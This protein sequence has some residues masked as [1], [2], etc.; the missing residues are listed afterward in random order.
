MTLEAGCFFHSQIV[1]LGFFMSVQNHFFAFTQLPQ[2]EAILV[3]EGP[4]S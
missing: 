1:M 2:Y 4:E 3:R